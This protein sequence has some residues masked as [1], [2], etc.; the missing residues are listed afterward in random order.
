M[1]KSIEQTLFLIKPDGIEKN[2]ENVIFDIIKKNNLKVVRYKIVQPEES[3]K[4]L[5]KHYQNIENKPFFKEVIAYMT[6]GP[7]SVG[8]IEGSDAI[9][10][11]RSIMGATNPKDALKGTIRASYGDSKTFENVV[12]GSDSLESAK[13][14]ISI[15]F[16][17]DLNSQTQVEVVAHK[18]AA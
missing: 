4:Y 13:K 11:W 16:P 8:I 7:I 3:I 17:E 10:K 2:L 18:N 15:W 14:E 6:R 12:H 9:K 5:K 1:D